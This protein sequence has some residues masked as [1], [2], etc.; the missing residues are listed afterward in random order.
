MQAFESFVHRNNHHHHSHSSH[1]QK[2]SLKRSSARKQQTH[3]L[4]VREVA[5]EIEQE[6]QQILANL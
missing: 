4:D 6:Q 3:M 5:K 2:S 1:K